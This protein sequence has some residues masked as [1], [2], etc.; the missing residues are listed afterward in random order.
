MA[1]LSHKN[2]GSEVK[3]KK[4]SWDNKLTKILTTKAADSVYGLAIINLEKALETG[5][6]ISSI[7]SRR[8]AIEKLK[9]AKDLL[10]LEILSEDEYD[11]LKEELTPIISSS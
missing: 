10:E 3:I 2:S 1:G 11:S 9:E 8:K 4:I 6:I 5:E 7:M